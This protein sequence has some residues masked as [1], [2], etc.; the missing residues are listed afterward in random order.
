MAWLI[1]FPTFV[2]FS[3][4]M[5]IMYLEGLHEAKLQNKTNNNNGE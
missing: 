1:F 2:T 3:I 4:P 5:V